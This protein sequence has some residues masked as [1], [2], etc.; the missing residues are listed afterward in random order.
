MQQ[1]TAYLSLNETRVIDRIFY[2]V[3]Q[4]L[5][6]IRQRQDEVLNK[7]CFNHNVP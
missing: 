7:W 2:N 6:S 3:V 5:E 4:L 1:N